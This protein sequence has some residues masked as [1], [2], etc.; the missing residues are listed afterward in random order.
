MDDAGYDERH[1]NESASGVL[2]AVC[3]ADRTGDRDI[4]VRPCFRRNAR[5]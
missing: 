1:K 3:L 5:R 4:L 2:A